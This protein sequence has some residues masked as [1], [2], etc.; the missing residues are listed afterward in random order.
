MKVYVKEQKLEE[1]YIIF[2]WNIQGVWYGTKWSIW[3]L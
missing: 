3:L 1:P 2:L